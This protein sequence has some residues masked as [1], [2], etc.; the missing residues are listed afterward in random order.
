MY[1]VNS[2]YDELGA[3]IVLDLESHILNSIPFLKYVLGV[4]ARGSFS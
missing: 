2:P 4:R 3:K 1:L